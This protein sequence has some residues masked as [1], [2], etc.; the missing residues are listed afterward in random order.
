MRVTFKILPYILDSRTAS[1]R[2]IMPWENKTTKLVA[3]QHTM[4]FLNKLGHF[5]ER[6]N[7]IA[8]SCILL[9]ILN[10][11]KF[12][13]DNTV[14]KWF[15]DISPVYTCRH[16]TGPVTIYPAKSHFHVQRNK[17]VQTG[18]CEQG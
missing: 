10:T 12:S 15:L 4:H 13:R 11:F 17:Q 2:R 14:W 18:R 16:T 3:T 9:V 7:F 5:S 8:E 6:N 1:P